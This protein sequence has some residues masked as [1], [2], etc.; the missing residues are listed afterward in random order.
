MLGVEVFPK[1]SEVPRELP[2]NRTRTSPIV[3]PGEKQSPRAGEFRPRVL[4]VDDE[5]VIADT[6]TKILTATLRVQHMTETP[7]SNRRY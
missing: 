2:M 1:K 6:I 5:T 7:R 3:S 4:V